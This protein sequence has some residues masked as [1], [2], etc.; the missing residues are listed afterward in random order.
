MTTHKFP[1]PPQKPQETA[2]CENCNKKC[3]SR[4]SVSHQSVVHQAKPNTPV[5]LAFPSIILHNFDK[6]KRR[7]YCSGPSGLDCSLQAESDQQYALNSAVRCC[8]SAAFCLNFNFIKD[9]VC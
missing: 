3:V 9:R 8:K 2:K 6:T 1:F 5:M 4:L 7:Q